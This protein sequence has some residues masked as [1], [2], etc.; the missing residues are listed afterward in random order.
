MSETAS[1]QTHSFQTEVKQ[2]LQLMIHSLYS[3]KEVFLRELISNG[4]DAC[5]RLRFAALTDAGLMEDGETLS[6]RV[7]IDEANKAITIKDNGIGMN[8]ETIKK[9]FE[10]FFTTKPIGQGSGLGLSMVYG[11]IEQHN[12]FIN[13]KSKEKSGTSLYLYFPVSE[14]E[15]AKDNIIV[16]EVANGNNHKILIVDDD[17]DLLTVLKAIFDNIGYKTI[18]ASNA[19]DALQI[20]NK[21]KNNISL[22]MTDVVMPKMNGIKLVQRINNININIKCIL[23]SGYPDKIF[24]KEKY[25]IEKIPFL[26]KPF[27]LEQA[28]TLI[29]RILK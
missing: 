10:P 1:P 20:V 28:S 11:L 13:V 17:L 27:T 12:A 25:N 16:G 22:V 2:L 19:S 15:I 21:E 8:N 6:I 29:M 14:K 23:M 26:R 5:D 24:K 7:S 3:N 9:V 4:S 18:I